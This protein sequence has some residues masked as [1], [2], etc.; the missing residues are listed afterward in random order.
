MNLTKLQRTTVKTT[1]KQRVSILKKIDNLVAKRD[2]II[3][4]YQAEIDIHV[5]ILKSLDNT[6]LKT[7]GFT[8]SVDEV[9]DFLENENKNTPEVTILGQE[10]PTINEETVDIPT[11]EE[12]ILQLKNEENSSITNETAPIEDILN[13]NKSKSSANIETEPDTTIE[14][15][16]AF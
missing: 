7:V 13:E 2:E 3:N 15:V 8:D 10:V 9:I 6:I 1:L 14:E 12:E 11:Q 4:Q 5:E 16:P